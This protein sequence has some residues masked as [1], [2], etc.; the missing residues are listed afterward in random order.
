MKI[1]DLKNPWLLLAAVLL[2]LVIWDETW[3][4]PGPVTRYH[5][6]IEAECRL[7]HPGFGGTPDSGC[8]S[9]K[10]KMKLVRDRGVHAHAPIK[11]CAHCHVEH[12]TREY[13]LA[14]AWVDP[15]DFDHKWTGFDLEPFHGKLECSKCHQP[16]QPRLAADPKCDG[17]HTDF[18]P[19]VWDHAKTGCAPGPLHAN[20]ACRVCHVSGW[21]DGLKPVCDSCHFEGKFEDRVL[22]L[23][24]F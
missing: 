19:G 16:G 22:C 5:A 18:F 15:A 1:K 17:C 2:I 9:C 23:D 11:K 14:S 3:L 24:P 12:R 21:G 7:C 10:V 6:S 20:L 13:P 4:M 8:L